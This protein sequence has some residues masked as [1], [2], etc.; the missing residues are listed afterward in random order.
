MLRK[1]RFGLI[2]VVVLAFL[3]ETSWPRYGESYF[4][5]TSTVFGLSFVALVA[6]LTYEWATRP[7]Q[8][9]E[10]RRP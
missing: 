7:H 4:D 9:R 6:V 1:V 10:R 5:V 8:G 3:A 2:V